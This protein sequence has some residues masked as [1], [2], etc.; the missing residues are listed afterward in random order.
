LVCE[1]TFAGFETS[2]NSHLQQI[3][4]E[5]YEIVDVKYSCMP[6]DFEQGTSSS[7]MFSALIIYKDKAPA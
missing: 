3:Q 1:L 5:P 7:S 6:P 2:L 4:E